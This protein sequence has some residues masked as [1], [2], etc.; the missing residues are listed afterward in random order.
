MNKINKYVYFLL[1][2][3]VHQTAE[4]LLVKEP[5]KILLLV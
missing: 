3:T 4:K 1:A 2:F 5:P